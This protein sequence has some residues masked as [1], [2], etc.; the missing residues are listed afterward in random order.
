MH[1]K[2][3]IEAPAFL[4]S[5]FQGGILTAD[6]TYLADVPLGIFLLPIFTGVLCGV[7]GM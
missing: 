2:S 6:L 4:R 7:L 1:T 3:A 5:L